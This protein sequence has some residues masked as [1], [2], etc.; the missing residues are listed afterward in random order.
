MHVLEPT[1]GLVTAPPAPTPTPSPQGHTG[2]GQGAELATPHLTCVGRGARDAPVS[3]GHTGLTW[4]VA[5][6]LSYL[7]TRPG[8]KA[9]VNTVLH[10]EEIHM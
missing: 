10:S 4:G 1:T 8:H 7:P 2:A 3:P 6:R 5:V 9:T